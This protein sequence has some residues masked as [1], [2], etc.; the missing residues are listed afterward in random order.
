MKTYRA[1]AVVLACAVG[2][3]LAPQPVEAQ[4]SGDWWEWALGEVVRGSGSLGVAGDPKDR[5]RS[6][7]VLSDILGGM[8]RDDRDHDRDER[9]ARG[10][11]GEARGPVFCRNGRGHP[12]HGRQWCRDKGFGTRSGPIWERR[13]WEDVILR[14]PSDDRKRGIMDQGSLADILGDVVFRRLS[15]ESRRIGGDGRLTG[16]WIRPAGAATVLQ[17]Q[18]RGLPVAELTDLDGDGRIDAVLV[19]RR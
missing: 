11:R 1:M 8:D 5:D 13:T 19:P 10:R 9:E 17:I 18:S 7:G 16:R 14:A 2:A 15:G 4:Q 12:V 3:V 6:G